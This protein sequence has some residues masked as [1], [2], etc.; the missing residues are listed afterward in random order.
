M[1][2]PAA[3]LLFSPRGLSAAPAASIHY[4][5]H[6]YRISFDL[7]GAVEQIAG[8]TGAVKLDKVTNAVTYTNGAKFVI[9][10][11][12]GLSP[13]E[14][15][16]TTDYALESSVEILDG[17]S[18]LLLPP[19]VLFETFAAAFEE[20]K[21]VDF[22]VERLPAEIL[23]GSTP[24][25]LKF[26]ALHVPSRR[27]K[28]LWEP[29]LKV[30]HL[31]SVNGRDAV[32]ATIAIPMGLNGL[33][34]TAV[35]E[36]SRKETNILLSLGAGG[37]IEE[38]VLKDGP[39]RIINY[40][41]AAGTDIAALDQNDLKNFWRW[42]KGGGLKIPS[43]APEFICSN[44]TVSDPA[45]A[46]VIK[47]YALRRIAGTTV[48][49]I[50]LVPSNS[51]ILAGLSGAP[52][53]IWPPGNEAA[54]FSLISEL[55]M[56]H[57]AKAIVAV[58]FLRREESGY[59]MS[60]SG[61]DALIGA[62]SWDT[63]SA[64]KTRVELIKWQKEK[65]T[66]PA[67]TVFPDSSGSGKVNLEFGRQ[68][69]LTAIEALPQDEDGGEP[70]YYQENT[71]IKERIVKHLLGSGDALLPDPK[72]M[73]LHGNKPYS[74]Y[75]IPDFYNMA[76]V[77][78]RKKLKAEVSVL[79]IN[80]SANNVLGDVPSSMVKTWL[81]PDEPVE[82]AWVTGSFLKKFYKKL[83]RAANDLDYY[84]ARFYQGKD[85]Y[86]TSGIDAAGRVAGLP[87]RD[88]ELYLTALPAGLL[89]GKNGF[90]RRKGAELT[91]HKTI[92]DGLQGIKDAAPAREAWE[93][94]IEEAARNR[95]ESRSIWRINLRSLSLQAV[96][97]SVSAAPGYS[98]VNE[99]RLSA[100]NQTQI[101]GSGRLFSEFHS[102]KFRL[103]S[104]ISADY[105]KLVLRPAASPRVTT[106]SVDQLMLENEL[107][108]RLKSY[109]G[110][111]GPLVIGPFATAAYETEFSRAG[112]LPLRKVLRGKAGLKLFEGTHLQELYAGLTTEQVYTYSPART[113]YAAET[114][115]R[116]AWPVPGTAL[117]LNADG[118]YRNFAR[119]RFDTVYDLKERLEVN[120]RVS[121]RLYGDIT[122]NP[123]ASYFL[124]S[125]K[126]LGGSGSN[127][128]TGFSLEYSRLFKLKR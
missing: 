46:H 44:I 36:A 42:S 1:A 43:S 23:T 75:S 63:A 121:A 61:I 94:K 98:G 93:K 83:P 39:E 6:D 126:K 80:P 8:S 67:I 112:S 90:Q 9:G 57:K 24:S 87:L 74:V 35:K 12:A 102:G 60:A 69:E 119:S 27:E 86:A 48:A 85:Y 55:R 110:A 107:R 81:G 53:T 113:K 111:L 58:S 5:D 40:L 92:I 3:L 25:G 101:Q 84:S 7:S 88:T 38:E 115:F 41:S 122:I 4:F 109:S 56:K 16:R 100:V 79:K 71:G 127:L 76:A 120:L 45:L 31:L 73:P 20:G 29:T 68:A 103:D 47:P 66:R 19:P 26:R 97:T 70:F 37:W 64:R 62:K 128:T 54:L 15:N 32:F 28:R 99:S 11:P 91:V 51:A 14:L 96:N 50:A 72:R 34:S 22:S 18:S 89:E 10:G 65:H 125:G 78:L 2:L 33:S 30:E 59:L 52:F 13:A 77:L 114:G 105:G 116:L 117:A 106:E 82:L 95:T 124:A 21:V 49:F 17:G 108:Y 118:T 123:F 104:G